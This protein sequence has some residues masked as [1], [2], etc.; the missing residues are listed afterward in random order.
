MAGGCL[1]D[2][3]GD[4]ADQVIS[5]IPSNR[6]RDVIWFDPAGD[7]VP[8]LNPLYFRDPEELSLAQESLTMI[9]RAFSGDAWG[10]ETP[11]VIRNAINAVCNHFNEPT[12]VHVFRFLVDDEFR[13]GILDITK[14]PFLKL[15]QKQYEQLRATEQMAKFSPAV[16]KEGKLMHPALVPVIGQPDS[17]DFLEIMNKKRIVICRF[18]KGRLGEDAAEIYASLVSSIISISALKRE[19][20]DVRPP[21]LFMVDEAGSAAHGGRFAS[22]LEESRKYGISLV[23]GFQGMYQLPFAHAVSAN[24]STKIIYNSSG[25]EAEATV[26][27][28]LWSDEIQFLAAENITALP[29]YAFY[30]RTF[31]GDTPVVKRVS[32]CQSVKR[33]YVEIKHAKTYQR[34]LEC[35]P[36]SLK[37]ESLQRYS[38]EKTKVMHGILN[39]LNEPN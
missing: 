36:A 7:R 8:P 16:N 14:N 31:Q 1:I 24:C 4:L 25:E 15:F 23:L 11:W 13:N 17:L 35:H 32:A 26:K 12:P 3:H 10:N 21:F 38:R 29:R 18:S 6:R 37:E 33:R 39:L 34:C 22:L 27:D 30:C 2:M 9:L 20:Q 19:R 5:L 28:W